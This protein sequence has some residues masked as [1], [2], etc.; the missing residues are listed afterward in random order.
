VPCCSI[1]PLQGASFRHALPLQSRGC[2]GAGPAFT[3]TRY[4]FTTFVS[5][6]AGMAMRCG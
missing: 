6:V 5:I 3:R 4:S 2:C 1:P